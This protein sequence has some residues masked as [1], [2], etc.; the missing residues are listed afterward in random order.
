MTGTGFVT[1]G[2]YEADLRKI[3]QAISGMATTPIQVEIAGPTVQ[4]FTDLSDCPQT[5]SGAGTWL[6]RVKATEDQLEFAEVKGSANQIAV[7]Q[8]SADVTLSCLPEFIIWSDTLAPYMRVTNKSDTERDPV[9]QWAVGA[10]PVAKFT[11]GIDDSDEDKWKLANKDALGTTPTSGGFIFGDTLY[12]VHGRTDSIAGVSLADF[13]TDATYIAGGTGSGDGQFSAPKQIAFD[14]TYI[15]VSDDVNNR[16]QKFL[17]SDGSFVGKTADNVTRPWGCVYWDGFIYVGCFAG[18]YAHTIRKFDAETLIYQSAFGSVGSGDNQFNYPRGMTTDGTYLYIADYNNNRI[19]KHLLDGTYVAKT[20]STGTGN[21]EFKGPTA[22]T[23]DGTSLYV[24]DYANGRVQIFLCSD[25]SY[26]GQVAM[27]TRGGKVGAP[28]AITLDSDYFY[29]TSNNSIPYNGY[30][31]KYDIATNTFQAFYDATGGVGGPLDTAWGAIILK[32]QQRIGD[33]LIVHQDGQYFDIYPKVRHYDAIRLMEDSATQVE[34]VGI[35]A[36][37][38]ITESYSLTLPAAVAAAQGHLYGSVTGVLAWGQDLNT[39]ASPEF[40]GLT[41]TGEAGVLKATAG[42]VSSDAVID[43][44]DDVDAAAPNDD[45]ILRFDT[46]SGTWKAE[47]L[48]AAGTHDLLSASHGDSTASAV[49]RGSIIVGDST[50]KWVE[51]AVGT[52]GQALVTDGT[53]ISWGAPTAA[54]HNLLSAIHGDTLTDSVIRGDILYGN[55]TPKWARLAKGTE[56]QVLTMGANEPAWAA[57]GV[58]ALALDDLSDVD[59]AAPNDNDV[60]TWD[61]DTSKWVA[62]AGGGG[63]GAPTDA[64]YIVGAAN[65]TLS[66]EKVKAQL[67]K[68]YD[69]DDTPGSPNALDDEFDDSSL[70]VKWT[71]VNNP[72]TRNWDETTF[73]GYLSSVIPETA[74]TDNFDNHHRIYQAMPGGNIAITIIAKVSLSVVGQLTGEDG[75]W[76]SVCI[77][78]GNP[79]DDQMVMTVLEYNNATSPAPHGAAGVCWAGGYKW[80]AS[81]ALAALGTVDWQNVIATQWV[82]LKL[83]KPD[84]TAWTSAN[85]YNFYYSLNGIVWHQVATDSITFTTAPTEIGIYCRPPKAQ[86][87]SPVSY[88]AIDFFRR[89]V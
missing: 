67:Y 25:L 28:M 70:D 68:N 49:S 62:A 85:T 41:L 87:G 15:Y 24:C 56:G 43:D 86:T 73:V 82:Y 38:A 58:G 88:P 44:L 16:V 61:S 2:K 9:N 84:A 3:R 54:A 33:L 20:G 50:P 74:A 23:T 59:A 40:A 30:I 69:I 76:S 7:A 60:L 64:Q 22:I 77:Y 19:K 27:Q 65:A 37:S 46:V 52:V 1:L 39:A 32:V 66:A 17:I 35:K 12:Y 63:G 5:Y 72:A 42:V 80:G 71:A 79:T 48:P 53:D 31:E 75:E 47:A 51:L 18:T 29:V 55:A 10:T 81:G 78:F 21:G 36:P 45:D 13:A 11:M 8:N 6:P 34:Y 83:E 4:V 57:P 26:V 14:E 89:I